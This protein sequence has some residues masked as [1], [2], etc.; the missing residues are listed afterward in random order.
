[1]Q[2]FTL[3]VPVLPCPA[4]CAS[5]PRQTVFGVKVCI[6]EEIP[7]SRNGISYR[8]IQSVPESMYR[9]RESAQIATFR[10]ATQV[11]SL[12]SV[13]REKKRTAE[14]GKSRRH[15]QHGPK[16]CVAT[17]YTENGETSSA[18]HKKTAQKVCFARC[19]ECGGKTLYLYKF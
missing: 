18:R 11:F 12:K 7:L 9:D 16:V 3:H 15:M 6:G 5:V 19:W 13:C 4:P 2:S 17:E 1:M 14:T 8:H 10:A